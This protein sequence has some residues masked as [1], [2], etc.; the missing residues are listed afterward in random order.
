MA[1]PCSAMTSGMHF[2]R[3]EMDTLLV[4]M[5]IFFW[6]ALTL[7]LVLLFTVLTLQGIGSLRRWQAER[8][9]ND[10]SATL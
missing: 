9:V 1:A 7:A 8:V 4:A 6:M 5:E 10:H 2:M 3:I